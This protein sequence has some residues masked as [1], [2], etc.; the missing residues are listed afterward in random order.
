M[1][2]ESNCVCRSELWSCSGILWEFGRVNVTVRDHDRV[3]GVVR[4]SEPHALDLASMGENTYPLTSLIHGFS[5][6][7]H[8]LNMC[9]KVHVGGTYI[10]TN[11]IPV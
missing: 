1:N 4:W 3:A 9:N 10:S 8:T 7:T 5:Y 11:L 2:V 6:I